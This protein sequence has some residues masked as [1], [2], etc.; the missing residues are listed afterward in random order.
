M[1]VERVGVKRTP[2]IEAVGYKA[3]DALKILIESQANINAA[4][5]DGFCT[6]VGYVCGVSAMLCECAA[7]NALVLAICRQAHSIDF[8]WC[9]IRRVQLPSKKL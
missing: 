6:Y 1:E 8:E 7:G 9:A 2:L 5:I 4:G 3:V